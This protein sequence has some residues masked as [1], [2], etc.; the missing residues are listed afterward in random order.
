MNYLFQAKLAFAESTFFY[1]HVL[2]FLYVLCWNDEYMLSK[3]LVVLES[4][5][6]L[7]SIF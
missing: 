7:Y 5:G 2:L 1:D 6:N 4:R 3:L